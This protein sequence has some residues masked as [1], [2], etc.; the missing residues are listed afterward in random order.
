[1]KFEVENIFIEPKFSVVGYTI[2]K[3]RVDMTDAQAQRLFC[4][5]WAFYGDA[6]IKEIIESEAEG[7]KLTVPEK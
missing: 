6:F 4:E 1:M 7:Y 2:L 5:I 3:V